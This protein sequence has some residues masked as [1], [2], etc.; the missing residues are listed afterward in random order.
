M[1]TNETEAKRRISRR[2]ICGIGISLGAASFGLSKLQVPEQK[3]ILKTPPI[4][5]SW[6][7]VKKE[8]NFGIRNDVASLMPLAKQLGAGHVR[9]EGQ[10]W[11]VRTN[12]KLRNSLDAAS[13][14]D[15]PVLYIFNPVRAVEPFRI[16]ELLA[17]ILHFYS[18][19][20]EIGNEVD[21]LDVPFWEDLYQSFH[22]SGDEELEFEGFAKHAAATISVIKEL[23][24]VRG[25]QTP[26]KIVL[27][28]LANIKHA[29]SYKECF[30]KM[31][32]NLIDPN[33]FWAVHAYHEVS[34]VEKNIA[35]LLQAAYP[36]DRLRITEIGM[37]GRDKAVLREMIWRGFKLT[38]NPVTVHELPNMNPEYE[39]DMGLA[40]LD[41]ITEGFNQI[42]EFVQ[43]GGIYK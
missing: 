13:W 39:P 19:E 14:L 16:K 21:N 10:A 11:D 7:Q 20:I 29:R 36:A 37:Q 40:D 27:G 18:N 2:R 17:P 4:F 38:R 15:L 3:P 6:Y 26:T 1:S 12:L 30:E 22:D 8:I 34:E 25:T 33:L 28:A 31:G 41:G 23:D 9:I 42:A 5:S 24:L 35:T 32:I 43:N